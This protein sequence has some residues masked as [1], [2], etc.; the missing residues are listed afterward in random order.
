MKVTR[1]LPQGQISGYFHLSSHYLLT[2][3]FSH[4]GHWGWGEGVGVHPSSHWAGDGN[5]P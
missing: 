4:W 2:A 3:P 1:G 5:T